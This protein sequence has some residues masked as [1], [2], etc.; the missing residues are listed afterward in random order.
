MMLLLPFAQDA[1][2]P[3]SFGIIE[4]G[5]EPQVVLVA[6]RSSAPPSIAAST[7]QPGSTGV[8]SNR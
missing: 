6:A 3:A 1:T 8:A 7:A 5:V 4:F 2:A